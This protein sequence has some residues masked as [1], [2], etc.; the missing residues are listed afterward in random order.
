MEMFYLTTVAEAEVDKII[1]NFRDNAVGWD[2][3]K[4]TIIKTVKSSINVPSAQIGNISFNTGLF[5]MELK[6][7]KIVPIFMSGEECVFTNYRP[8]PF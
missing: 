6:I 7:D 1:A 4:P 5:P 8:M 2:V 3:L